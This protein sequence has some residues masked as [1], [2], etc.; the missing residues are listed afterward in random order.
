[1]PITGVG[2]TRHPPGIARSSWTRKRRRI[3]ARAQSAQWRRSYATRNR[4][5]SV[6]RDKLAF[7]QSMRAKLRL[8]DKFDMDLTSTLTAYQVQYRANG[9]YD[10]FVPFGGHQPRGFDQYM[11]IYNTYTVLGS[12]VSANVCYRGYDGPGTEGGGIPIKTISA[13]GTDQP[14][15]SA[16]VIGIHKGV[17][18][19]AAGQAQE[20]MEK[21]RTTWKLISP[22][23]APQTLGSS[24]KIADFYGKEALVGS[25]GYTGTLTT[26]PTEPVFFE[27]WGGRVTDVDA[28]VTK[29]IWYCTIEYDVVFTEPKTLGSS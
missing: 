17:E 28:G 24:M 11:A 25:A 29:L 9:M 12:T 8:V 5:V 4:M 2:V 10:P 3:D 7:P 13:G 1:M 19:L 27:F 26:D 14:A 23:G 18:T 15:P 16:C 6:P 22:N 21:D 20:Q